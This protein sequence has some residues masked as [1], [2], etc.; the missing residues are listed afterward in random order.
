MAKARKNRV[1][2][3]ANQKGGVAKTTTA[4]YLG[5]AF[6]RLNKYVLMVDSDPQSNLTYSMELDEAAQEKAIENNLATIYESGQD[7]DSCTLR[8]RDNLS[9]IPAS[10][11]LV[12]TELTLD[13]SPNAISSEPERILRNSLAPLRSR[14]DYTIIDC[15]PSQGML[16]LNALVAADFL[17]IPSLASVIS[18]TGLERMIEQLHE[19]VHGDMALNADLKLLGVLL[20]RFRR[21]RNAELEIEAKL[22]SAPEEFFV[23]KT[24]IPDRS[25][26]GLLGELKAQT[27]RHLTELSMVSYSLLPYLTLAMEIEK[28]LTPTKFP[29]ANKQ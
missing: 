1:I 8:V 12:M 28:I 15:P 4:A 20:T 9:L 29:A 3:V 22:R 16:T 5:A 17:I 24:V 26:F 21:D 19:I 23:F 10:A 7:A 18:L 11:D 13:S 6:A 2:C 25:Q 27:G 14:Y